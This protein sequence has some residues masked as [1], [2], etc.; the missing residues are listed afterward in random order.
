LLNH[1]SGLADYAPD[2]DNTFIMRVLAD[3][4]RTW[5]PRE[6]V[7]I[8]TAQ[9]PHFPP[10]ERWSY[11]NTGYILLGLVVE[12]A[13]GN[14]LETELRE[15]VIAPLRLRA[16]SF[17]SRARIAGRHAHGY[18]RVGA[19]RRFDI[20]VLNQTWAGAAGAIVSTLRDVARFHR[21]LLGG[22]LLRPDLLAQ[23]RTT[24]D[25][26]SDAQTYGLGLIR[27]RYPCG[28]FWGHGGET[29]GYLS[30][31]DSRRGT[32]RQVMIAVTAD[33]S[34]FRRRTMLALERLREL[35]Y[36]G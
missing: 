21:A 19:T 26:G 24:V 35:A 32:R 10:G 3:R 9:P 7:A 28:T 1:T 14:P 5:D 15:R 27:S 6:L 20:S 31:A 34:A 11:S 4:R 29:L 12:A 2:E 25:T 22:R 36:C 8:G 16:T 30:Y 33:Q 23:M 13:T 18:S 17:D